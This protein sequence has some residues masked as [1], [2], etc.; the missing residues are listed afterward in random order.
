MPDRSHEAAQVLRGLVLQCP[1]S[2]SSTPSTDG[3]AL[4]SACWKFH[5]RQDLIKTIVQAYPPALAFSWKAD[6]LDREYLLPFDVGPAGTRLTAAF[7]EEDTLEMALAVVEYALGIERAI[8]QPDDPVWFLGHVRRTAVAFL[9]PTSA[10]YDDISGLAA[11][12]TL[13]ALDRTR[14]ADLCRALFCGAWDAAHPRSP[15]LE[16]R[17]FFD[18]GAAENVVTGLFRLNCLGRRSDP[19]L[20]H[21]I[22]L[23]A[24]ASDNL[25]CLYLQLRSVALGVLV[26]PAPRVVD[27]PQRRRVRRRVGP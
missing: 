19:S 2:V 15:R 7:L 22:R 11:A 12:E 13:R 6:D 25:D 8:F 9:S 16:T 10:K 24:L 14:R 21:Q 18:G 23:V 17:R 1:G 5:E 3:T 4:W 26:V 20:A 27:L